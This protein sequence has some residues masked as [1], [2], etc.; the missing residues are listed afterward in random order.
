MFS[1][2]WEAQQSLNSTHLDI[3]GLQWI[4]YQ[5]PMLIISSVLTLLVKLFDEKLA[6]WYADNRG[7][8]RKVK[9]C[10]FFFNCYLNVLF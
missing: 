7:M 6:K 3:T 9:V 2:Y 1:R 5:F 4:W 10:R 8:K